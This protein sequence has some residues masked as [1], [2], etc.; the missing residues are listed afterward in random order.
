MTTFWCVDVGSTFTKA[1]LVD[2]VTGEVRQTGS[3]PTTVGTDVLDGVETLRA[4]LPA[5]P[6]EVLVCS[7]ATLAAGDEV[8]ATVEPA[9]G[10]RCPRSCGQLDDDAGALSRALRGAG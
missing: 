8:A 6:A 5:E 9:Q 3:T 4:Q 10:E 1:V 7:E 2:A